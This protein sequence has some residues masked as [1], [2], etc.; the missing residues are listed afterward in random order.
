MKDEPQRSDM[1]DVFMKSLS[2]ADRVVV[3][4]DNALGE[5]D[6]HYL[7]APELR[8]ALAAR[9][10]DTPLSTLTTRGTQQQIVAAHL[11]NMHGAQRSARDLAAP[12]PSICAGGQHSAVI[13][14]FLQKYYGQGLGQHA[15]GPLHTLGTR[16]TFGLVTVEIDGQTYAITDI[17][18]RMLIPREQFRAQGF[19]D[20]YIIDLAPDGRAM[21]K[22]EQTRMCGNSVCPPLAE[23]LVRANCSTLREPTAPTGAAMKVANA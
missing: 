17:G 12:H 21:T 6:A 9:A 8:D 23:A 4:T 16:D 3:K 7:Y 11:M 5:M 19:P 13:A 22:T 15:D 20:S 18:M 1:F 10:A 14:A 2:G